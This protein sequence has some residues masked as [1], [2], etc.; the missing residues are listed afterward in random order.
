MAFF[1]SLSLDLKL[2]AVGI[3]G[4][5]L[6]ALFSGNAKYEKRY[7]LVFTLLAAGGAWRFMHTP[8]HDQAQPSAAASFASPVVVT[9]PPMEGMTMP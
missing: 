4:C 3:L 8:G 1:N 7:L 5:A 9:P 2:L 6:L